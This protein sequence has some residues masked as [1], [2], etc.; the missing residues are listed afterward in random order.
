MLFYF[1]KNLKFEKNLILK[2]AAHVVLI[3]KIILNIIV[4]LYEFCGST[5]NVM[6]MLRKYRFA[7]KLIVYIRA[8][9]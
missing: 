7:D 9:I 5:L 2:L 1:I 4:K 3:L 6:K 8:L